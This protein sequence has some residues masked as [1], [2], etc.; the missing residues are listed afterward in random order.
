MDHFGTEGWPRLV[1]HFQDPNYVKVL[2]G[3][4]LLF[5]FG[6]PEK[7]AKADFEQLDQQAAAAGVKEP[8]MVLMGWNP[9]ADA[10]AMKRFGFHAVSAYAAGVGYE[11][12]QW[13][14]AN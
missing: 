3:R 6:L 14:Y 12:E 13:P 4:P 7:L 10:V 9:K 1:T 11:W 2:D 5:V 8:Y